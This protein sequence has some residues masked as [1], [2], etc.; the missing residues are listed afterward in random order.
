MERLLGDLGAGIDELE[1]RVPGVAVGTIG[2][3]FGGATVWNL[4]QAG[5]ARLAAAAPFYGPAPDDPDFSG[6]EAAVFAAYAQLDGRVNASRDGATAAL[7]VA[8][9]TH[10]VKI[11]AGADH[12]FFNDTGPRYVE[13][14]AAE[15]YA[16]VLA[17]FEEYLA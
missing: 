7:E 4:L 13:A 15:A 12:A 2:F 3:C 14:A 16:D 8:G 1:R 17:W 9:L 11:Y 10:V 6:A 5:E